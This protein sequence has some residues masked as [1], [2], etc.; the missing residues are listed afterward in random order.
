MK[1]RFI[2]CF[3]LLLLALSS[4][5]QL[6]TSYTIKATY[7]GKLWWDNPHPA[8]YLFAPS[9]FGLKRGTHYFQTIAVVANQA[10]FGI[11]DNFSFGAGIVPS[12]LLK[13]V[14]I[15]PF[16]LLPKISFPSY[17]PTLRFGLTGFY[18]HIIGNVVD[19][20]YGVGIAE[21]TMTIGKKESNFTLGLGYGF[22]S[23]LFTQGPTIAIHGLTRLNKQTYL[24][25]ENHLL[26]PRKYPTYLFSVGVRSVFRNFNALEYGVF[27]PRIPEIMAI[28]MPWVSLKIPFGRTLF[29]NYGLL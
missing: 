27:M 6:D 28:P 1:N 18:L 20:R 23:W 22:N 14:D 19:E 12:G 9:A 5:G 24:L 15:S 25:T 21:A 7:Q 26:L 13:N 8:H 10:H 4:F 2:Y 3:F 11:T 17:H 16:W 29:E